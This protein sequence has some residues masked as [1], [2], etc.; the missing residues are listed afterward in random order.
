[1]MLSSIKTPHAEEPMGPSPG[2]QRYGPLGSSATVSCSPANINTRA[3]DRSG[4]P[5]GGT[6]PKRRSE[7]ASR[8]RACGAG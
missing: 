5:A 3:R 6:G 4:S 7:R 8:E 1:M 2:V